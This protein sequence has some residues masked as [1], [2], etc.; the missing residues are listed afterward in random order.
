[1]AAGYGFYFEKVI[2]SENRKMVGYD[3]KHVS[4]PLCCNCEKKW[5]STIA[6]GD[7]WCGGGVGV[8]D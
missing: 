8:A 2:I 5:L 3:I 7:F 6:T 4:F 1:M